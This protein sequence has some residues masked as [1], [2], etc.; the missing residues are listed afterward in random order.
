[1]AALE[2]GI[3][4]GTFSW[5]YLAILERLALALA[6]G[7]FTGFERERRGK[8]AGLR[9]F[10]FAALLGGVG[11]LLGTPFALLGLS[12]VCLLVILLNL[13]SLLAS[14]SVE[15]TTSVALLV[16]GFVG[17]LAGLGH[18]L[19]PTA[20]AIVTAGLLA[21]K[22]RLVWLTDV[23]TEEE[24]RAGILLAVLAFVVYPALPPGKVD[25]WHLI[26]AQE[27][28][29]TVILIAA[30]GVVNYA[31]LKLLGQRGMLLAGFL[32][33]LANSKVAIAEI[34]RS[35]H[36]LKGVLSRVTY[37]T[38]N[39]TTAA[40]VIRNT[41]L[42][43]VLAPEAAVATAASSGLMLLASLAPGLRLLKP[44]DDGGP[45]DRPIP[46]SS[47]L[48]LISVLR[49]GLL[50]L[51]LQ[52]AGSLAQR[53]F[54]S[55]GF[56]IVCVLGGFVSSASAVASA[57]TLNRAHTITTAVAG[58]GVLLTTAV[59][60]LVNLILYSRVARDWPMTK[61]YGAMTAIVIVLGV[62]GAAG[63]HFLL[64]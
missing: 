18:T 45:S 21:S 10:G 15:L 30:I 25:P 17:V 47:P 31:L 41:G 44:S 53:Q 1:M 46:L 14:G 48:S 38:L 37:I 52:V 8:E 50:F 33:A 3:P 55:G 9:T 23:L 13:Q 12:F 16:T 62:L 29:V 58:T 34:A 61:R 32:G 63:Q 5:P 39:F 59:S 2:P 35:S 40:V 22:R 20:L 27:A 7:L 51:A 11:G 56:F 6:L 57:A 24:V 19:T 60:I 28:W 49:F 4:P 42:L 64:G 36:E 26:D 43:L 54:G